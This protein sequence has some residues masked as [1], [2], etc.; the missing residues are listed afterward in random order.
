MCDY[1]G[2]TTKIII[3]IIIII[4]IVIIII[5]IIILIVNCLLRE[6]GLHKYYAVLLCLNYGFEPRLKSWIKL[7]AEQPYGALLD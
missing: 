1:G 2:W 6:T 3:I 5:A 4:I 7:Q